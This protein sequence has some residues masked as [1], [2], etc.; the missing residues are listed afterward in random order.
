MHPESAE[1]TEETWI[2]LH[3]LTSGERRPL[4]Q[5]KNPCYTFPKLNAA[6]THILYQRADRHPAGRQVWLATVDG[7]KDRELFNFG[8]AIKVF[9]N[10]HPDGKRALV[11]AETDKQ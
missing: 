3:D 7:L 11:L 5:P 6:G 2:Y 10:W 8:D 1:E 4:A 9:A